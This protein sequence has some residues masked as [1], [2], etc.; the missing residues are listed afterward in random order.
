MTLGTYAR[1]D[2]L[3][4]GGRTVRDNEEKQE[5]DT[6]GR[7][8]PSVGEVYENW[9]TVEQAMKLTRF[10]TKQGLRDAVI[11]GR[12]AGYKVG[13]KRRGEWRIDPSTLGDYRNDLI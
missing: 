2:L 8:L 6:K 7:P 12:I 11:A 10:T 4:Q 13:S 9:L 3:E 5:V 1:Y